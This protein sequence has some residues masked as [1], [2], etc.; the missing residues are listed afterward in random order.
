MIEI[1]VADKCT[2]CGKRDDLRGGVCFDCAS[3]AERSAARRSVE[4]HLRHGL[5]TLKCG[6]A[7]VARIYFQWA[8][9]RLTKTGDYAVGGT[10]DVEYP[11]WR[12]DPALTSTQQ[13]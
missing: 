13:G 5:D 6:D 12:D 8:L 2:I 1:W 7:E 9:E 10:F 3:K 4:D 11:G